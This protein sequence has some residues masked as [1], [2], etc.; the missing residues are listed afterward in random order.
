MFSAFMALSLTPA[1]CATP[2]QARRSQRPYM[3][4]KKGFFGWFNRGFTQ[5]PP[6]PTKAGSATHPAPHRPLADRVRRCWS[7]WSAWCSC[8]CRIP[9]CPTKTRATS[10]PT[11]SCRLA[12]PWNAPARRCEKARRLHPQAAGSGLDGRG[13]RASAFPAQGQNMALGFIT[14]KRL[15]RSA[16]GAGQRAGHRGRAHQG[17]A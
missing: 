15:G 17:Q 7:A 9:S 4:A 12:P 5:A 11:S 10:S 2:A 13:G 1:L 6:R 3:H 16:S 8:A 14:L